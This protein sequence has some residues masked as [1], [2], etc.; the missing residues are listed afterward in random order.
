MPGLTSSHGRS[1][2]EA[3]AVCLET[4]NHQ[5]GALLHLEAPTETSATVHWKPLTP[6]AF[7]CH[8][9]DRAT[10]DGACGIAISNQFGDQSPGYG[11]TIMKV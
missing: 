1:L 8:T 2:G 9:G 5:S 10:E 11:S 7:R 4:E 3:V 6:P